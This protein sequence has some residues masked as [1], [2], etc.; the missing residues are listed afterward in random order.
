[1]TRLFNTNPF[2]RGSRNGRT[3]SANST[4]ATDSINA[5]SR[6]GSRSYDEITKTFFDT[7]MSLPQLV[8]LQQDMHN[9]RR[10]REMGDAQLRRHYGT[11]NA[12]AATADNPLGDGPY[13]KD[14]EYKDDVITYNSPNVNEHYYPA[15]PA[16]N[17]WPWLALA[18]AVTAG[19]W[20]YTNGPPSNTNTN[21]NTTKGWIL[22]G[23]DVPLDP[24]S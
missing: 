11:E 1:M 20:A 16:T 8:G 3:S 5:A 15:Q 23:G 22:E 12:P 24:G 14:P 17:P 4:T 7:A 2:S 6:T 21:T 9:D 19:A 10:T 18:A 13:M